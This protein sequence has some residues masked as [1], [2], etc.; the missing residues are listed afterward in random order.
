[1]RHVLVCLMVAVLTFL[2]VASGSAVAGPI[3]Y[4]IVNYPLEQEGATLSG[5]IT[6]TGVFG[7][8][9]SS[10]ILSWNFTITPVDGTP[11]LVD[12]LEVGATALVSGDVVASASSITIAGDISGQFSL[13]DDESVDALDYVRGGATNQY[14]GIIAFSPVWN[15]SAST[16]G[17]NDTW[18]IATATV[19]EPA[20]LTLLGLGAV[21]L[22]FA[23]GRRS[24][25]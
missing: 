24:H 1:M 6:T 22:I 7:Q 3:T 11:I 20:S 25:A 19:P 17:G 5:A 18:V 10:S 2:T 4:Q 15:S 23:T 8:L 16:L 14:A 13:H 21:G 12:S 9:E